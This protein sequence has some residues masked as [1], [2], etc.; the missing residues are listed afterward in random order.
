[1]VPKTIGLVVFEQVAADEL[2]GSAHIFSQAKVPAR[3]A[4]EAGEF[5]C[6]RVLTLGVGMQ[7]V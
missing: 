7:S 2:T 4:P 1:M 3:D 6:Y 5:P